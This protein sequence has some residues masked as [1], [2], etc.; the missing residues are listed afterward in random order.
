MI[1]WVKRRVNTGTHHQIWLRGEDKIVTG[2]RF[3][4]NVSPN[5]EVMASILE[6]SKL[7]ISLVYQLL[8]FALKSPMTTIKKRLVVETKSSVS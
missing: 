4:S 3:S 7:V 8:D 6:P 1:I 5:W 2:H